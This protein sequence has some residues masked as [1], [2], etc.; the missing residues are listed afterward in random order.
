MSSDSEDEHPYDLKTAA[1]SRASTENNFSLKSY[2]S[3]KPSPSAPST[4]QSVAKPMVEKATV[5]APYAAAVAKKR[6]Q[7]GLGSNP[8][9]STGDD[10]SAHHVV[11]TWKDAS[12]LQHCGI[13]LPMYSGIVYGTESTVSNNITINISE[14]GTFLEYKCAWPHTTLDVK[15]LCSAVTDYTADTRSRAAMEIGFNEKVNEVRDALKLSA[16][17]VPLSY[18]KIVLPFEVLK[19]TLKVYPTQCG[20]TNGFIIYVMMQRKMESVSLPKEV[21]YGM[22]KIDRTTKN[23]YDLTKSEDTVEDMIAQL[24]K[25]IKEKHGDYEYN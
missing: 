15:L 23:S 20:E 17:Q 12:L 13:V 7:V 10:A 18:T 22:K 16:R 4:A 5:T 14:C 9:T 21:V 1:V 24:R 19:E 6:I 11:F 25:K 3:T 8:T 2:K